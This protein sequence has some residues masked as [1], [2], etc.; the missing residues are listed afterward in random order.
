MPHPTPIQR[1]TEALLARLP[2]LTEQ[3]AALVAADVV[4]A[5]VGQD[6]SLSRVLHASD[7][8]T[9]RA[10]LE[11]DEMDPDARQWYG[12]NA[13]AVTAHLLGEAP[14]PQHRTSVVTR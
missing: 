10:G 14:A 3:E 8:S 12:D 5:A 11:F 4:Q 1:A 6:D 2:D 13:A 7:L 9:G